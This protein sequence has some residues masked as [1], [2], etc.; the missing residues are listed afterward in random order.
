MQLQ[1]E[2]LRSNR[3]ASPQPLPRPVSEVLYGSQG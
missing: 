1:F 3:T 2:G